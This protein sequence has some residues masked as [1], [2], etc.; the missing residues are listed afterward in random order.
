ML[1]W[2]YRFLEQFHVPAGIIILM[3]TVVNTASLEFYR[4]YLFV[5]Q[6]R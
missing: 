1:P 4:L 5:Q 6:N 3:L 2:F